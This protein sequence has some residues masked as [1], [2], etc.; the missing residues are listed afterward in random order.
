[1]RRAANAPG[2]AIRI[3]ADHDRPRD[4]G[5]LACRAARARAHGRHGVVLRRRFSFVFSPDSRVQESLRRGQ[6]ARRFC[7]DRARAQRRGESVGAVSVKARCSGCGLMR[8][9]N[10][11]RHAPAAGRNPG[12]GRR[13]ACAESAPT[14]GRAR[15]AAPGHAARRPA[16][17]RGHRDV[18]SGRFR[19][20]GR[21]RA[22]R[23]AGR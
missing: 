2:E 10:T 19:Q 7:D 15:S 9:G 18:R 11:G 23:R 16:P 20:R 17:A 1:M 4:Q 14:F 8:D 13:R 21:R 22:D 12:I 6:R 3:D 5:W